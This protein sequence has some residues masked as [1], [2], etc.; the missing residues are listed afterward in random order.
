MVKFATRYIFLEEAHSESIFSSQSSAYFG[1]V[2][3]VLLRDL[4]LHGDA[5]F[6]SEELL[7][8]RSA[9]TDEEHDI[10]VIDCEMKPRSIYLM[11]ISSDD[12]A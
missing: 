1:L 6:V 11:F 5:P 2:F 3:P 4:V 9:A 8:C 7:A 12:G 10:F